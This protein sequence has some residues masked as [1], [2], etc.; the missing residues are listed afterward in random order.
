MSHNQINRYF[1]LM[2]NERHEYLIRRI[3]EYKSESKEYRNELLNK[4]E[5][6]ETELRTGLRELEARLTRASKA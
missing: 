4:I 3:Q 2:L 6:L 5:K 1:E